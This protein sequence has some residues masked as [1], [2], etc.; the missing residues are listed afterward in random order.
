MFLKVI[1]RTTVSMRGHCLNSR[2][3][4][5]VWLLLITNRNR[6]HFRKRQWMIMIQKIPIQ[7]ITRVNYKNA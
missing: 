7:N 3:R 6:R 4:E 1:Q 2:V 5:I